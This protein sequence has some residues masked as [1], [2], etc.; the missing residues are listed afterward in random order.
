MGK[1]YVIKCPKGQQWAQHL[2]RCEHP[3]L[4]R[5]QITRPAIIRP[6]QAEEEA[7]ED[8][9]DDAP[10]YDEDFIIVDERCAVEDEDE[11]MFH[12]IKFAH[13]TNCGAFYMCYDHR[14]FKYPCPGSLHYNEKTQECDYPRKARCKATA[15]VI[16]AQAFEESDETDE[17]IDEEHTIMDDPDYKISHPKCIPDD[18][19]DLKHPIMFVHP[20]EC[21]MFYK[22]MGSLLK[23]LIPVQ[24]F[25]L[26]YRIRSQ[27]LQARVPIR[28]PLQRRARGVRLSMAHP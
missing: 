6:A 4:A 2:N 5:C 26:F 10:K 23:F 22:C 11:D 17:Y 1:A 16:A 12:P 7:D 19:E 28:T 24:V 20:T 14:A 18:P 21:N 13:P 3:S 15:A 8:D 9:E 25:Q 27:S